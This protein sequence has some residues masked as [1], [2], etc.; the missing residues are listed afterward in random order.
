[1][2]SHYLVQYY[3][4]DFLFY[5]QENAQNITVGPLEK[6]EVK[7]A[8][9]N[10]TGGR[11]GSGAWSFDG[12]DTVFDNGTHVQCASKHL[13]SF[14]VLVSVVPIDDVV[15]VNLLPVHT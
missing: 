15:E 8:F 4:I 1:M 10:F 2:P 11:N 14:V 5:H 7:C 6:K 13:T 9:W 3:L 12:I